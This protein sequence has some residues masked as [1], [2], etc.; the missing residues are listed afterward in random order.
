MFQPRISVKYIIRNIPKFWN[1]GI[2]RI[3]Y[4]IRILG[5]TLQYIVPS[6]LAGINL[7][8][9]RIWCDLIC[10]NKRDFIYLLFLIYYY[11]SISPQ[12]PLATPTVAGRTM[13]TGPSPST[14][15]APLAAPPSTSP[16]IAVCILRWK[17][18]KNETKNKQ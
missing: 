11:F 8:F 9:C 12:P 2:F 7:I 13:R 17:Q 15:T 1:F 18:R 16:P 10:H 6:H 5:E 14:P 4:F 3:I